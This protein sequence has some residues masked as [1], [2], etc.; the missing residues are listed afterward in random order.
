MNELVGGGRRDLALVSEEGGDELVRKRSTKKIKAK[1]LSHVAE[2]VGELFRK[3]AVSESKLSAGADKKEVSLEEPI[4]FYQHPFHIII[5][6]V[7]FCVC[8]T[9]IHCL[10]YNHVLTI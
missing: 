9:S 6:P 7:I 2:E 5:L 10:Q 3:V 1:G 4:I 8:Q